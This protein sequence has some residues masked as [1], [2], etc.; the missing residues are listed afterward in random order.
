LAHGRDPKSVGERH[1]PYGDRLE[2]LGRVGVL[3]ELLSGQQGPD[4]LGLS[5][6]EG[7]VAWDG[8]VGKRREV[9]LVSLLARS[10]VSVGLDGHVWG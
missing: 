7:G 3:R 1:A 4:R 10:S 2:G 5:R 9:G 6:E 8:R